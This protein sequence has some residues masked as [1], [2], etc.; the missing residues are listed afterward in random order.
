MLGTRYGKQV[1][2]DPAPAKV[3]T[4]LTALM[5]VG[6]PRGCCRTARD[7]QH[8]SCLASGPRNLLYE[9]TLWMGAE[10]I[11]GNRELECSGPVGFLKVRDLSSTQPGN[12]L[13]C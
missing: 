4:G 7:P 12:C 13:G 2:C 1:E 8:V 6:L 5:A 9:M 10:R 3:G 11:H